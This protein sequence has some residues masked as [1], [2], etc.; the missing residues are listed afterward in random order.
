VFPLAGREKP[1]DLLN[2]TQALKGRTPPRMQ[3]FS[4]AR[5]YSPPGCM[6]EQ[7]KYHNKKKGS[8]RG[9]TSL[10]AIIFLSQVQS[11]T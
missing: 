8:E 4:H 6:R 10:L 3:E 7:W 9:G 2:P 1:S 5:A 11:F